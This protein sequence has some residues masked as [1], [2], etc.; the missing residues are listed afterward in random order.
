[1]GSFQPNQSPPPFPQPLTVNRTIDFP[2]VFFAAASG[3]I[4]QEQ[5]PARIASV[6]GIWGGVAAASTSKDSISQWYLG[7]CGSSKHLQE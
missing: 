1:M 4:W 3:M 2:V 7:W 6:S 5:A